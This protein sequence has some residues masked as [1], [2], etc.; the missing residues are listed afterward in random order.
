VLA[1]WKSSPWIDMSPHSTHYPHSKP[2]RLCSYSLILLDKR[3]RGKY[4][5]F[6]TK[7]KKWDL[8]DK[9]L[10]RTIGFGVGLW[11]LTP[12]STFFQLYRGGQFYWWRKPE[13]PKKTIDLSQVTYNE[14]N[15]KP[16]Q[17]FYYSKLTWY[18][19]ENCWTNK[20][21]TCLPLRTDDH[22]LECHLTLPLSV[23]EKI[24][25][26]TCD[27]V[28]DVNQDF[29]LKYSNNKMGIND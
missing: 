9:Q 22:I 19:Q 29:S 12:H 26:P 5:D 20:S 28:N 25:N 11:C 24:N 1:H 15:F 14:E 17:R 10:S 2:I 4:L 7:V 21:F 3:R 8:I 27:V 13:Y 6:N 18:N 23:I 16:K